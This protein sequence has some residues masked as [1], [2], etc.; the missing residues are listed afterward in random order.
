[1][2]IGLDN[3]KN[4][5]GKFV[6]LAAPFINKENFNEL[7]YKYESE[8]N[9][10]STFEQIDSLG[11]LIKYLEK[12]TVIQYD[13]IGVLQNIQNQFVKQ[14]STENLIS[15]YQLWLEKNSSQIENLYKSGKPIELQS[16]NLYKSVSTSD[17]KECLFNYKT[18]EN[19]L[20]T[21]QT[22][23]QSIYVNN[24]Q[25]SHSNIFPSNTIEI[26]SKKL[27]K[28][29]CTKLIII[30]FFLLIPLLYIWI[31]HEA[32]ILKANRILETSNH[33]GPSMPYTSYAFSSET[34]YA[35]PVVPNDEDKNLQVLGKCLFIM[36]LSF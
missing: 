28:I 27:K 12:R 23:S 29:T 19:Y 10:K 22:E 15:E 8:I 33:S 5:L 14:E 30:I 1:M 18:E 4:F 11:S 26:I 21:F 16:N 36:L 13:K 17:S 2:T 9:S 7:K 6:E 32:A 34:R 31:F 20:E 3:Y 35:T 24:L 25:T